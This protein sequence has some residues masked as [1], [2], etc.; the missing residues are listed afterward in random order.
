MSLSFLVAV[1]H[2]VLQICAGLSTPP[3]FSQMYKSH[4]DIKMFEAA[5]H[6]CPAEGTAL[7]NSG[8][9]GTFVRLAQMCC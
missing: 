5:A 3:P 8:C 4:T 7:I 6:K 9:M 2:K 1:A